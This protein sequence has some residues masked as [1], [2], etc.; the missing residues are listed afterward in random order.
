[1][2][3]YVNFFAFIF[4]GGDVWVECFAFYGSAELN[5]LCENFVNLHFLMKRQSHLLWIKK[6][7][8]SP[9]SH[10]DHLTEGAIHQNHLR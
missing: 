9:C 5:K 1:M 8:P 2:I 10:L 3:S 7:E 6:R 4:N